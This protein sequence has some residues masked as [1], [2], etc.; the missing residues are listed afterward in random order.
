MKYKTL[1]IY[2]WKDR[3]T[4]VTAFLLENIDHVDISIISGDEVADFYLK[5]GTHWK[6]D[7]SSGKRIIDCHDGM[8]TVYAKDL[9]AW[10][11][12]GLQ[13]YK[14][15]KDDCTRVSYERQKWAER[16]EG[17]EHD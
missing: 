10:C 16:L 7:S 14:S 9:A 1:T 11:D 13:V 5:D 3:P 8:Y 15:P 12:V 17:E 6:I 2:D 4:I